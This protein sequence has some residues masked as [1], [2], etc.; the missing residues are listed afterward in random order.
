MKAKVNYNAKGTWLEPY[1][2]QEFEVLNE[3]RYYITIEFDYGNSGSRLKKLEK[4]YF[5]FICN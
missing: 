3:S 1:I 2:G 4:K 5:N